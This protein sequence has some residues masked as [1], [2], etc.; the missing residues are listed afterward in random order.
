[1]R[2][3]GYA[4]RVTIAFSVDLARDTVAIRGVFYGGKDF[5][6]LL[7]NVEGEV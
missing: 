5:E 4:K 1:L 3:V 2:T 7:R 6:A